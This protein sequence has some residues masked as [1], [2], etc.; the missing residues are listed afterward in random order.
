MM[1]YVNGLEFITAVSN[2]W[3]FSCKHLFVDYMNLSNNHLHQ[4][5]PLWCN[6]VVFALSPNAGSVGDHTYESKVIVEWYCSCSK[7][8]F[9]CI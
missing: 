5:A 3:K 1:Y 8:L 9:A 4:G 6:G 7:S 2:I